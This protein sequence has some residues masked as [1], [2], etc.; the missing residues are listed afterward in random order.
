M[1]ILVD[2]NGVL[3]GDRNDEPIAAGIQIVGAL[4]A[5]NHI[6]FMTDMTK[7]ETEYWTN[8]N[9]VI[10][11]DVII[12]SSVGVSDEELGQRQIQVARAK[13]KVDLFITSNPSLWVYAFEQGIPSI[14]FGT[15][16]YLRAEFRPDGPKAIRQWGQIEQAIKKQNEA[17]TKDARIT[18]T[19]TLNF[20]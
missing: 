5:Y 17:R 8:I 6:S 15:P 16:P 10:D 18:R 2:I 14:M 3:K 20:E 7:A 19:E 1:Q 13:G 4:S 12:D 9:K 11:Y